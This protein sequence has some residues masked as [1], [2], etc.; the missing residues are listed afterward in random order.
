MGGRGGS[1]GGGRGCGCEF[2]VYFFWGFGC[3]AKCVVVIVRPRKLDPEDVNRP[4]QLVPIRLEFD[5]EH[6]KMR[7]T[8]VWNLNG[9]VLIVCL[10][11]CSLSEAWHMF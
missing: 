1:R 5:V 11:A 3:R 7:D 10:V 8:F 9:M 2:F 4:E 6:H